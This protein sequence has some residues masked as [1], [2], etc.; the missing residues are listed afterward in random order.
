MAGQA[1]Q[2]SITGKVLCHFEA[3]GLND[4]VWGGITDSM[5]VSLNELRELVRDREA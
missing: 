5:D 2:P 4:S 3:P 1:H